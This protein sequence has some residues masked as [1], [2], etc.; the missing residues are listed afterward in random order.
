MLVAG[1]LNLEV[2]NIP[3]SEFL[4]FIE[5]TEELHLQSVSMSREERIYAERNNRSYPW[6]RRLLEHNGNCFYNYRNVKPFSD[7]VPIINQLPIVPSSRTVLL[8]YQNVQPAYDFNWHFDNDEGYGFR[9][10]IGLDTTVSFLEFVRIKN[11]FKNY[12]K[13]LQRI[14][15]NMVHNTIYSITPKKSNT[16]LYINGNQYPH[17][18][19][20]SNGKQRASIIVRGQLIP[21]ELEFCQRIDDEFYL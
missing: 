12:C 10:C 1:E 13:T 15:S 8:L 5:E 2:P 11:E 21:K 6:N 9:I 4:T 7:I 3:A 18:V 20:I 16:V 14:E 17:R 19:P